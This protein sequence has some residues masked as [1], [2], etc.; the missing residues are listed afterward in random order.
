[1]LRNFFRYI[2]SD[3]ILRDLVDL[4]WNDAVSRDMLDFRTL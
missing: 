2:G 4:F 1:M 3:V